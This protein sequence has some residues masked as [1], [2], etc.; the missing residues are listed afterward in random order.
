MQ[1]KMSARDICPSCTTI[2]HR[3][4]KQIVEKKKPRNWGS[5]KLA[6]TPFLMVMGITV[7]V[8]LAHNGDLTGRFWADFAYIGLGVQ[9]IIVG[10]LLPVWFLA[11]WI[12]GE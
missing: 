10:F 2:L 12:E 6:S 3:A 8:W 9:A 1:Y 5:I 4:S 11:K 7:M